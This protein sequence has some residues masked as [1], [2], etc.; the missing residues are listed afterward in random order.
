MNLLKGSQRKMIKISGCADTVFEEA[1]F[2]LKP[3][4]DRDAMSER[5]II[6]E[7]NR[8]IR[9]STVFTDKPHK[10]VVKVSLSA[11]L[12]LIATSVIGILASSLSI[13]MLF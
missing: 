8:I 12:A 6:A 9:E 4:G 3:N 5:E 13:I 1:Y 11:L 2:I 10:R 7:A